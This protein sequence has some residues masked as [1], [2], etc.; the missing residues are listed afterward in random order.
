MASRHTLFRVFYRLGFTPWDGHAQATSLLELIQ[1]TAGV[2]ALS[3]GAALDVGCGTGDSSIYLAE[4]GWQVTGVDFVPKALDKAR[5][6][7]RAAGASVNFVQADVT[8][9]S[10]AGIDAKFQLIVDN[11]CLHGMSDGDRDRYVQEI[12]AAAAPSAR[13]LIVAAPPGG[14]VRFLG[15]DQAEVERRFTPAWVLLSTAQ[16]KMGFAN[17]SAYRRTPLA[18]IGNRF[19]VRC[20]LLQRQ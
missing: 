12:T 13:L 4:H 14:P 10:H 5:A 2:P 15:L 6:K 7:A 16:E 11:G 17:G 20:Y 1:G 19:A 18:W 8:H 3:P 9:L